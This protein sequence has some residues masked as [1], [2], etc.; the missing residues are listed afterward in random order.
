MKIN[1]TC[2]FFIPFLFFACKTDD[3]A[4]E[5]LIQQRILQMEN[6]D[7]YGAKPLFQDFVDACKNLQE[8]TAN[9]AGDLTSENLAAVQNQWIVV[10]ELFKKCELYDIGDVNGSFIQFR[11]HRWPAEAET[12]ADTLNS[13]GLIT[14]DYIGSLG[15]HIIG[16]GALE[17]LLFEQDNSMVLS[18]FQN[19]D[20]YLDYLI[21]ATRYLAL[22]AEEM[23]SIWNEYS[24]VFV[25]ATQ[26]RISGG[27]NQMTN[28]LLAFLEE[29]ARNRLGKALG[30]DDGGV[31]NKDLLEAHRS[32]ASLDFIKS[33]FVEWKTYFFGDFPNSPDNYGFDDYLMALGNEDLV[34]AIN[35]AIADCDAA[36]GQLT[37]LNSDLANNTAQVE[38]LKDSFRS[39]SVL[40]K[41]DLA[42]VLGVTITV[43]DSDGD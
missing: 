10:G 9:F 35:A 30:E 6:M 13:S 39:L 19:D 25:A 26:S 40:I 31:L 5:K 16:I 7:T 34:P 11:I 15:S 4:E 22:Q 3:N 38:Q 17:Y 27:Q 1:L 2:F 21:E 33:G 23:Q 28:A 42:S 18:Q 12:L 20:R 41:A 14:L 29:T 8:R 36:L 37:D 24:P 43:N 32:N